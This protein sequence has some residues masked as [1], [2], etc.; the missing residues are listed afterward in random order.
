MHY[1]K[2]IQLCTW[3]PQCLENSQKTKVRRK[4]LSARSWN[5][6]F[7][8]V[9]CPL[10]SMKQNMTQTK[11]YLTIYRRAH[12][13]LP[14]DH[15]VN[16]EVTSSLRCGQNGRTAKSCDSASSCASGFD[17]SELSN[18]ARSA[19]LNGHKRERHRSAPTTATGLPSV[20]RRAVER[21]SERCAI[22][23]GIVTGLSGP[24]VNRRK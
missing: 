19:F 18:S 11:P 20:R 1:L 5:H 12:G 2:E 6:H 17:R 22:P 9:S 15:S 13:L 10:E 23:L 3:S 8:C 16:L 24:S 4:E 21:V 7:A 14:G